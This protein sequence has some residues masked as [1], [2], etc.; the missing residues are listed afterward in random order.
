MRVLVDT[1]IILDIFLNRQPFSQ[2]ANAL[3]E[4]IAI[5]Q[6]TG[7]VCASSL[8]DIF[9]IARRQTQSISKGRQAV[10]MTLQL[11]QICLVDRSILE[12]AFNSELADFEDAVQIACAVAAGLDAIV[13]RNPNDFQT[14]LISVIAIADFLHQLNSSTE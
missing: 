11:F 13:T 7:Y 3:L 2:L 4:A 1:N 5:N 10:E 6:A 12:I 8:T 14:N 9:Y